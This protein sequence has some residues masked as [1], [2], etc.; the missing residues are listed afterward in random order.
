MPRPRLPNLHLE[1][2]R[3]GA[4]VWY[5]RK[6]KDRRIRIRGEYGTPDFAAAYLAAIAGE[7]ALPK[8]AA[9][10]SGSLA[11]LICRYRDSMAWTALSPATRK[12]R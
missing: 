12:Q 8:S 1:Y 5:F 10:A 9:V 3:H 11:W 7:R 2:T 6:G 4:P